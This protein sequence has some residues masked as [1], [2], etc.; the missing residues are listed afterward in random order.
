VGRGSVVIAIWFMGPSGIGIAGQVFRAGERKR[1]NKDRVRGLPGK[2]PWDGRGRMVVVM[3]L[4]G[5]ACIG[6]TGHVVLGVRGLR[7]RR[8]RWQ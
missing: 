2:P 7:W 1:G 8:S 3:W 5:G 6:A 4:V